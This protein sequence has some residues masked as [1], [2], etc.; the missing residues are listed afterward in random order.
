MRVVL[1]F[2]GGERAL[3]A[4]STWVQ[5][6]SVELH[7]L[8]VLNPKA[9]HETAAPTVL[10][11]M[12]PSGGATGTRVYA[13]EPLAPIVEDRGQAF[14]AAHATA[15]EEIAVRAREYLGD[16]PITAEARAGTEVVDEIIAYAKRVQADLIVVGAHHRGTITNALLGSVVE[17]LIRHSPFPVTVVG[18]AVV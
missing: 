9:I 17:G 16:Y 4:V 15:V 12:T 1:A 10:H 13:E 7:I 5:E 8:R 11:A 2:D 6:A 18:P 14:V 3:K